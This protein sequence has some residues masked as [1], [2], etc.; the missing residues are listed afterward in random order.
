MNIDPAHPSKREANESR[1]EPL[2]QFGVADTLV[3]QISAGD[4]R[5]AAAFVTQ[6]ERMLRRRIRAQL[7][8]SM[9]RLFDSDDVFSTVCRR[10]DACVA[11][12]SVRANS[13]PELLNL[14]TAIARNSIIDKGRILKRFELVE[15]EDSD[16]VHSFR[17]HAQQR[18]KTDTDSQIDI[19]RCLSTIPSTR[20]REILLFWLAGRSHGSIAQELGLSP[21]LTR[22]RW[23]LIKE[24]IR[25]TLMTEG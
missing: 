23:Q 13:L 15:H 1:I 11:N 4:R 24:H 22:K 12:E 6:Y 2:M 20:D 25:T 7:G 5:A 10:L 19:D 17:A 14:L 3:K 8:S 18:W 9:R 16:F 21:E